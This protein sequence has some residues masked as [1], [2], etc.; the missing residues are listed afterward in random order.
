MIHFNS[1]FF[2]V[3]SYSFLSDVWAIGITMYEII[4]LHNPFENKNEKKIKSEL[5][6]N[7]YPILTDKEGLYNN[8]MIKI[9]NSM[10][11]VYF[12]SFIYFFNI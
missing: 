12:Y 8:E 2:F 6:S 1:F 4:T 3:Y 7:N 5:L 9:I 11:T 10:L